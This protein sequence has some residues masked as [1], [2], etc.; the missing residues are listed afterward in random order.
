M[1]ISPKRT[2][3]DSTLSSGLL[4][5]LTC[6]A[7]TA[8]S[9]TLGSY[10]HDFATSTLNLGTLWEPAVSAGWS[11]FVSKPAGFGTGARA[12]G[13]HYGVALADNVN[14]K[15]MRDF[16]FA[17]ASHRPY[18]Y[19]PLASGTIPNRLWH[20]L[21][22]TLLS[23]QASDAR[24]NWSGI[25]ASFASAALSNVYQ[26]AAQRTL[27]AT[28]ERAGTDTAGYIVG[29]IW[30]EFTKRPMENHPR[31]RALVKSK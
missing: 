27:R 13:Y 23:S 10:G 25:P 22:F 31:M 6:L 8:N 3:L 20:A 11:N 1:G 18:H 4:L 17:A 21:K 28:F 19:E 16:A 29:N 12:Y 5:A 7:S 2:R 14:G 26:P 9:Q 30:L 15:F 24:F